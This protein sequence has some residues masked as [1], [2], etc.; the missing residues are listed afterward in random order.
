M[1]KFKVII[2]NLLLIAVILVG[3]LVG[4]IDVCEQD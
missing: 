2:N 3:V 4:I 1:K